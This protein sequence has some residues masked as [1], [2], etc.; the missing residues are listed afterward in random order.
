MWKIFFLVSQLRIV[1]LM[2]L[3]L[4]LPAQ[5]K[6]QILGQVWSFF[7]VKAQILFRLLTFTPWQWKWINLREYGRKNCSSISKKLIN[8]LCMDFKWS[9][10]KRKGNFE[11]FG[12]ENNSYS[13]FST[14]LLYAISLMCSLSFRT[15]L[16]SGSATNLSYSP[17]IGSPI[18]NLTLS[19]SLLTYPKDIIQHGINMSP[20]IRINIGVATTSTMGTWIDSMEIDS[21]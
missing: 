16:E 1:T 17:T 15:S 20:Q 11:N 12:L 7:I 8:R 21:P 14:N 18:L 2:I 6:M 5:Y 13:T 4:S 19:S 3:I 10:C 9:K